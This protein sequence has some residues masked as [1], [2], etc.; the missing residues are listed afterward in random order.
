MP[1]ESSDLRRTVTENLALKLKDMGEKCPDEVRAMWAIAIDSHRQVETGLRATAEVL[2]EFCDPIPYLSIVPEEYG[3]PLSSSSA[4]LDLGCLGGYGLY[5]L[6]WQRERAGFPVPRLLGVDVEP[7][8]ISVAL[9]MAS[10]WDVGRKSSF[11]LAKGEA[12]P[13]QDASCD[14]IIARL[15]L[16]YVKVRETLTEVS[17]IL[18]PGGLVL[19]QL[20]SR[21]YYRAMAW[22][23]IR[24][25]PVMF[26]YL[27]P[28]ISSLIMAVTGEQ[29][30]HRWFAETAM[31]AAQLLKICR[32]FGLV[33]VWLGPRKTKPLVACRKE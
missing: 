11:S 6:A 28:I 17:R 14:V 27:R 30:T 32:P 23:F 20:H 9:E 8:Y 33:S 16:P 29:P 4:V 10:L 1:Q 25:P 31:S 21:R 12:M 13:F 22:Q 24:R 2:H 7:A 15:L 26:Y 19:F 18:K 3:C 5:D